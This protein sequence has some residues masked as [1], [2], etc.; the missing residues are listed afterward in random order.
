MTS[1]LRPLFGPSSQVMTSA[2][3]ACLA[4]HQLS[5]TTATPSEI[6]TMCFTPGIDFAFASSNETGLPPVTGHCASDA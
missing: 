1:V 6:C 4:R 3:R 2:S 5:A